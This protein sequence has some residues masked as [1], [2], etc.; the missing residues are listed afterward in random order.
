MA[1]YVR[2]GIQYKHWEELQEICA[3]TVWL[4]ILPKRLPR[5]IFHH[6]HW[7][8]LRRPPPPAKDNKMKTSRVTSSLHL[9]QIV[10]KPTR[11]GVILDKILTNMADF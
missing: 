8:D 3:E 5:N 10:D 11:K 6:H 4:T 7:C 9:K 2:Q 1:C